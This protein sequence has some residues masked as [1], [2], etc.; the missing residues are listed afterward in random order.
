MRPRFQYCSSLRGR[1]RAPFNDIQHSHFQLVE[2]STKDVGVDE[3][4]LYDL[5]DSALNLLLNLTV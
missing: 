3:G 2:S 4:I 1:E 5:A